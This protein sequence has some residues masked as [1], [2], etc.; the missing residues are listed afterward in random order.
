[1]TK[2]DAL[3]SEEFVVLVNELAQFSLWPG[4]REPP[5]GWRATGV[6]G[7]RE[8]CLAWVDANW[9]DMRPKPSAPPDSSTER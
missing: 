1:M 7:T 3:E 2:P 6:A 8:A 5:A 4:F 9:T